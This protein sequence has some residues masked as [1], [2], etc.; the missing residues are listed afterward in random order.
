MNKALRS[1]EAKGL[2]AL[3]Y[4]EI[5]LGDLDALRALAEP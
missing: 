1:L 4:G 3:R 2:V 5:E